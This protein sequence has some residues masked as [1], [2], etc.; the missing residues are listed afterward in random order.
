MTKPKVV[1]A[2]ESKIK[3]YEIQVNQLYQVLGIKTED[4]LFSSDM[5]T[6][7]MVVCSYMN[8]KQVSDSYE[9]YILTKLFLGLGIEF[10]KEDL[11]KSLVEI[12]EKIKQQIPEEKVFQKVDYFW[13]DIKYLKQD[14]DQMS[15]S[16]IF[17][18]VDQ[19]LYQKG[20]ALTINDAKFNQ[21]TKE[22]ETQIM[23][24]SVV[25]IVFNSEPAIK[26]HSIFEVYCFLIARVSNYQPKN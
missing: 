15:S 10:Q 18:L 6:L 8:N 7:S 24:P 3:K 9:K 22:L 25:E 26:L 4:V 20:Y 14:D 23:E 17:T 19:Y 2:S 13:L 5:T 16:W 11:N 12:C 1:W 21:K